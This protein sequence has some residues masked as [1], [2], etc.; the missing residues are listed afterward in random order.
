M[1]TRRAS[2]AFQALA[3]LTLLVT[4]A[5]FPQPILAQESPRYG[6]TLIIGAGGDPASLNLAASFSTI[7]TLAAA[8]IYS[9]LVVS[10]SELAP[11]PDLAESWKVSD[12]GLTYTFALV[13]NA[14]W[15]DGKPFT[16]ADVKF[17]LAE[18]LGKLH[19]RGAVV[20]KVVDS[21]ETPNPHTVVLQAEVPLRPP[22]EVS[23]ER[24]LHHR[25][26]PLREHR[27]PD[28]IRT[29]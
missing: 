10:D 3:A 28:R 27:H 19:P 5:G 21:I 6:G 14:T 18:V 26:A 8:N 4:A 16:S 11:Q 15:H 2:C 23:R 12:D 20:L 29:T 24:G 1:V 25:Q 22:D 7:D 9:F 17:S 13:K